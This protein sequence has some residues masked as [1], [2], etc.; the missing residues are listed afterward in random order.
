MTIKW[1]GAVPK[2][3]YQ[4]S[5]DQSRWLRQIQA[6]H[7]SAA[8]ALMSEGHC[9][10]VLVT[11]DEY[12]LFLAVEAIAA[13]SKTYQEIQDTAA[14]LPDEANGKDYATAEMVFRG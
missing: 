6:Q 7:K 14:A 11:P 9:L 10:G 2:G 13:N 1:H 12:S 8:V 5:S 3:T 4:L